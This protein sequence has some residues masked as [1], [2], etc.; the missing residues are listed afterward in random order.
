[1][2]SINKKEE[3][4]EVKEVKQPDHYLDAYEGQ[5]VVFSGNVSIEGEKR[6]DE[7]SAYIDHIEG[8][9]KSGTC[10]VTLF[11][12]YNG[13]RIEASNVPYYQNK[14]ELVES[15]IVGNGCYATK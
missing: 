8:I 6:F 13:K 5:A 11:I 9:G 1:M 4:K 15:N 10:R 12:H 14:K 7:F 2:N 3:V